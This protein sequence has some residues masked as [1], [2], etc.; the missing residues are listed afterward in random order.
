MERIPSRIQT[1]VSGKD[2]YSHSYQMAS[3]YAK[4][5]QSGHKSDEDDLDDAMDEDEVKKLSRIEL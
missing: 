3:P 1:G 4:Y 2:S 5:T